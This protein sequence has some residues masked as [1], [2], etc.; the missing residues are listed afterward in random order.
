MKTLTSL[1]MSAAQVTS[2]HKGR[3]KFLYYLSVREKYANGV[4]QNTRTHYIHK[5]VYRDKRFNESPAKSTQKLNRL[6]SQAEANFV[7]VNEKSH[8]L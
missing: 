5:L 2:L 8:L 1:S 3:F 6:S 4:T 7:Y